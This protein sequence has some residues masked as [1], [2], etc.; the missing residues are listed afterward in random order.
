MR[1]NGQIISH[2]CRRS[3]RSPGQRRRR[4]EQYELEYDERLAK[5]QQLGG[6]HQRWR[7]RNFKSLESRVCAKSAADSTSRP[8]NSHIALVS[9]NMKK[10]VLRRK[11]ARKNTGYK[12]LFLYSGQ[13][14]SSS[15]LLCR[16][17]RLFCCIS[18]S[19]I[20]LRP[21]LANL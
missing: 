17:F 6:D 8:N 11:F 21:S 2:V 18:S 16:L 13:R 12:L 3:L 14:L 4:Y 5:S 20:S 9:G 10:F 15:R 19:I 1:A 7:R